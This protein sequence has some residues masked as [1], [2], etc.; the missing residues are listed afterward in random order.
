M[1]EEQSIQ[2]KLGSFILQC[3]RVWHILRK[4][5][6]KEFLAITKISAIGILIVGFAGFAIS[7]AV[8]MFF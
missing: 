7:I 6:R 1:E 8:K 2:S 3:K 5:T 4:P